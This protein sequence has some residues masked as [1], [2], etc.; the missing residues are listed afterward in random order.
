ML[1]TTNL[2]LPQ[3]L[4]KYGSRTGS[5]LAEMCSR[6]VVQLVGADWRSGE[7]PE[8]SAPAEDEPKKRRT[9]KRRKGAQDGGCDES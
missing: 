3:I 1:I 9:T 5:R 7:E 8:M 2:T 6:R 4:R